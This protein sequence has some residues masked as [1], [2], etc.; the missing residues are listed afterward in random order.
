MFART[1]RL[2]LRPPWPEDAPALADAIGHEAVVQMLARAPWPY[3]LDDATAWTGAPHAP[4]EVRFLIFAHGNGTP[5]LVGAIGIDRENREL[6]YWITP[7]AWHR[8]YATEAGRAVVAIARDGLRLPHLRASW[9][10]DNPA[11]GRVLEKLG[12][13]DAGRV[14]QPSLAR[15]GLAPA[16]LMTLGLAAEP[17]RRVAIAA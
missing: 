14:A 17:C 1:E 7:S 12:F 9:F 11:S 16:T 2:T 13:R 6:G 3:L 4:D 10:T 15:G 5:D 8:G